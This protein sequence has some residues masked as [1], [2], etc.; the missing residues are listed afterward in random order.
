MI[1]R[2]YG[3]GILSSISET[4]Y[5]IASDIPKRLPFEALK[6]CQT[7]YRID[8]IQPVYFKLKNFNQLY[9]LAETD[10]RGLIREVQNQEGALP[11][12]IC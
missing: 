4:V 3:G 12:H 5:A 2:A 6:A 10:I 7:A 11:K 9:Q 1:R 8:V